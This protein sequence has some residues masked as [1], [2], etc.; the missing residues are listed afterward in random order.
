M[1]TINRSAQEP[2]NGWQ[3]GAEARA[4]RVVRTLLPCRYRTGKDVPKSTVAARRLLGLTTL[5]AHVT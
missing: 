5:I 3:L 4:G 1:G 2:R